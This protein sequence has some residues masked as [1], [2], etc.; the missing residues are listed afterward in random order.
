MFCEGSLGVLRGLFGRHLRVFCGYSAGVLRGLCGRGGAS[1]W[2]KS[3]GRRRRDVCSRATS[4]ASAQD[5]VRADEWRHGHRTY[6]RGWPSATRSSCCAGDRIRRRWCV[7]SSRSSEC[8]AVAR[9]GASIARSRQIVGS[10][11]SIFRWRSCS[12]ARAWAWA[13][14]RSERAWSRAWSGHSWRRR[15]RVPSLF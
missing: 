9:D 13:W 6:H 7:R 12:R 4:S 1:A 5:P 15:L 8:I 14:A 2:R 10:Y 3:T 11:A